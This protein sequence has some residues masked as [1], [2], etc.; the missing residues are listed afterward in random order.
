MIVLDDVTVHHCVF[1]FKYSVWS[2]QVRLDDGIQARV[3]SEVLLRLRKRHCS[4]NLDVGKVNE[5]FYPCRENFGHLIQAWSNHGASWYFGWARYNLPLVSVYSVWQGMIPDGRCGKQY[6]TREFITWLSILTQDSEGFFAIAVVPDMIQ[7]PFT[8][9]AC[10]IIEAV[11]RDE[12]ILGVNHSMSP[13]DCKVLTY[14]WAIW[15]VKVLG[16][17]SVFADHFRY[18]NVCWFCVRAVDILGNTKIEYVFSNCITRC[19]LMVLFVTRPER[20]GTTNCICLINQ[21]TT[22][23][24]LRM[25]FESRSSSTRSDIPN[26]TWLDS[27]SLGWNPS[28]QASFLLHGLDHDSHRF[29][30]NRWYGRKWAKQLNDQLIHGQEDWL[31]WRNLWR[32]STPGEITV[33]MTFQL[34][35]DVHTKGVIIFDSNAAFT[36]LLKRTRQ[37]LWTSQLA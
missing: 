12:C 17:F 36:S 34:Q 20:R 21:E 28:C 11:V 19:I 31:Q 30:K 23:I 2:N 35:A 32:R 3:D 27:P 16:V 22:M 6:V 29:W 8:T 18:G 1:G 4:W 25:T 13:V 26:G 33:A 10:G 15:S 24:S 5:C 37:Q 14:R 9:I 7:H